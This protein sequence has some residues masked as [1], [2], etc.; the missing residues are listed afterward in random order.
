MVLRSFLQAIDDRATR[1]AMVHL[2]DYVEQLRG[3]IGSVT[4]TKPGQAPQLQQSGFLFDKPDF[5]AA[6]AE[7]E[8]VKDTLVRTDASF[9]HVET[10][11][12]KVGAV[13]LN[14]TNDATL[15]MVGQALTVDAVNLLP[16]DG[17]RAYTGNHDANNNRIRNV[18]VAEVT[19]TE[20]STPPTG[21][22]WLDTSGSGGIAGLVALVSKSAAYTALDTDTVI[23]CDA[24]S[25]AFTITL[26]A[27]SGRIGKVYYVK[28]IDVSANA[29]TID[30]NASETIDD[31]TT[32]VLSSQYD[33]VLIVGDG[34]EWWIL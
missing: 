2:V 32:K 7:V 9:P 19:G 27:A 33:S 34:S 24:T 12:T 10:I 21:M 31:T 29:V 18:G 16:R 1:E 15:A 6:T 30:G 3:A 5:S 11:A 25:A 22:V 23:I 8:G 4:V 28:K 26:P 14:G 17:D 13:T 20:P